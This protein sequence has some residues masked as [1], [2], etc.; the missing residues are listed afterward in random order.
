MEHTTP[1]E[2]VFECVGGHR[3]THR[4]K[5]EMRCLGEVY[6]TRWFSYITLHYITL[7][8]ITRREEGMGEGVLGVH[9]RFPVADRIR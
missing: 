4:P 6:F 8:Y 5:K 7:H 3:V 9:P 2:V 1:P